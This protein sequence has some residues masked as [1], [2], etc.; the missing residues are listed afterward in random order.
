M[1]RTADRVR[2]TLDAPSLIKDYNLNASL[3]I[4]NIG[5]AF[6]PHGSCDPLTL[7]FN[8]VAVYQASRIA[9]AEL[10]Y[11]C[12]STR[13]RKAIGINDDN[14]AESVSLALQ[15]GQSADLVLFAADGE[16]WRTRKSVA[17][18]V[19][20]YDHCHGRRAVLE[21]VRTADR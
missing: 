16:D 21:G 20:L 13:A 4:N 18:A 19:Y 17:E 8:G 15:E 3:G 5:N 10:L 1:M 12:V 7:A 2:G 9:D 11:Q 14:D 6:T